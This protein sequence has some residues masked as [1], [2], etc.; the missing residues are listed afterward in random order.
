MLFSLPTDVIEGLNK[1]KYALTHG[2][3]DS[4]SD[5]RSRPAYSVRLFCASSDYYRPPGMAP[6]PGVPV[7]SNRCV[8]IEYPTNPDAS[9]DSHTVPFKER[10]LRGKAGSAPPLDLDK[11]SRGLVRTPGR[12]ASLIMGH[13][14][15]TPTKK[16]E[17]SKKFWFQVVYCEYISIEDLLVKLESLAP[18]DPEVEL[19]RRE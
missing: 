7:P 3:A 10:G 17:F 14:G 6:Y 16:K 13:T 19:A 15:P 9:V 11:S 18:T 12:M 2:G 4:R 1:T 8:P 5:P